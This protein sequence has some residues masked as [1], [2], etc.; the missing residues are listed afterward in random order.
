MYRG[1]R[2]QTPSAV[3]DFSEKRGCLATGRTKLSQL[4][5]VPSKDLLLMWSLQKARSTFTL[6][7]PAPKSMKAL[8]GSA[9]CEG[10]PPPPA[11]GLT[12]E[13]AA[14]EGLLHESRFSGFSG[15]CRATT[16]S[17]AAPAL[18]LPSGCQLAPLPLGAQWPSS[19]P[20]QNQMWSYLQGTTHCCPLWTQ[21]CEEGKV[22][23]IFSRAIYSSMVNI[24]SPA[25]FALVVQSLFHELLSLATS[26]TYV[27]VTPDH[28]K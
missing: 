14:L 25:L 6:F 24:N 21:G 9:V 23:V 26:I 10:R 4:Q 13:E 2:G 22:K 27:G 20:P 3:G 11:V 8:A 19:L 15:C 28:W 18:C 7:G 5:A 12:A 16:P 17:S 1:L